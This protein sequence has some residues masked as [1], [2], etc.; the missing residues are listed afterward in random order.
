MNTIEDVATISKVGTIQ[1]E[2]Y[3]FMRKCQKFKNIHM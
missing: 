1:E 3:V 2:S